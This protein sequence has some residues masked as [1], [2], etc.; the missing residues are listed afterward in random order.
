MINNAG[1]LDSL[2]E[3]LHKPVTME[4]KRTEP[5][6]EVCITARWQGSPANQSVRISDLSKGGCYVDTIVGVTV[7]EAISLELLVPDGSWFGLQ[8]VVAYHYPGLGFGIRFVN[9]NEKQR[10]QISLLLGKQQPSLP[11]SADT[12]DGHERVIP[13]DQIDL[14]SRIIM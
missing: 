3:G 9:L 11:E 4:E 14:T 6:F 12:S 10:Q 5:R 13:L 7:G 1:V 8:G 2:F